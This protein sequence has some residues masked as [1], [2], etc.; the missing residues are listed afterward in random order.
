[1][2]W[3]PFEPDMAFFPPGSSVATPRCGEPGFFW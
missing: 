2:Q 3:R 1:V